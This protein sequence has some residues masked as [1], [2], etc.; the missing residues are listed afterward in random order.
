MAYM[1]PSQRETTG[2]W[3]FE[4]GIVGV[5]ALTLTA[6]LTY[7]MMK[8]EAVRAEPVDHFVQSDYDAFDRNFELEGAR[9]E[10]GLV[11]QKICMHK[12]PME[13]DIVRGEPLPD[14]IPDMGTQFRVVVETSLKA[15]QFRTVA[16]GQT[17]ALVEPGSRYVQD[18]LHLT[19]PDFVS[20]QNSR[21]EPKV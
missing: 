11:E 12:S 10:L 8:Q 20:A 13:S 18:V 9:C 17:L 5:A 21:L 2:S 4:A 6:F 7:M 3:K 15:D 1:T 14:Y 16:Y 19:A